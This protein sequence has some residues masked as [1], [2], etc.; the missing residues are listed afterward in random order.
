MLAFVSSHCVA[1]KK[2]H[3]TFVV[4]V[5]FHF[6][7]EHGVKIIIKKCSRK[8]SG[9][10]FRKMFLEHFGTLERVDVPVDQLYKTFNYGCFC[11]NIIKPVDEY[12]LPGIEIRFYFLFSLRKKFT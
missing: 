1:F 2:N 10:V 7:F 6:L 4:V 11:R 9:K 5:D 12:L 3:T 8:C